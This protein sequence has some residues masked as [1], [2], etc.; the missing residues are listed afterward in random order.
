[1]GLLEEL[2][3][4]ADKLDAE[5]LAL[6]GRIMEIERESAEVHTCINALDLAEMDAE[7]AA[8]EDGSELLDAIT[9]QVVQD[10]AAFPVHDEP[11]SEAAEGYAPV[12]G[13]G[14]AD[15]G[16][17]SMFDDD[18]DFQPPAPAHHLEAIFTTRDDD[19]ARIEP[20]SVASSAPHAAESD[21]V[22]GDLAPLFPPEPPKAAT[23][24]ELA[25]AGIINGDAY[26]LSRKIA[27]EMA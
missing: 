22:K 8:E 12:V 4:R 25:E 3:D 7:D 20:F 15:D 14:E 19:D 26:W 18:P 17:P 23:V 5:L 27:K 10:E 6:S 2:K 9:E 11:A 21:A 1:M 16:D 24:E 13:E